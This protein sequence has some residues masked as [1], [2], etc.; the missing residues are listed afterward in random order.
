MI[1]L[2][3]I[4]ADVSL[5]LA[6]L[7]ALADQAEERFGSS[8]PITATLG[9]LAIKADEL[10]VALRGHRDAEVLHE[11]LRHATRAR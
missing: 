11:A 3:A 8:D 2:D 4:I 5:H 7:V 1:V 9:G 10:L 6:E